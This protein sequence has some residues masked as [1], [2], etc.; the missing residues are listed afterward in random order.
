M[1]EMLQQCCTDSYHEICMQACRSIQMLVEVVGMM[2][3]SVSKH[4]MAAVM[5][6]LT[7]KRHKVNL[8]SVLE[9]DRVDCSSAAC[10]R[11]YA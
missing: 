6:L 2:L 4:L 5:P 11:N 3:Y 1:T 8:L 9:V 7:H 10:M